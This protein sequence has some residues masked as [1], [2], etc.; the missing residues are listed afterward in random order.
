MKRILMLTL[1]VSIVCFLTSPVLADDHGDSW[2]SATPIIVGG[3]Y[4][5]ILESQTDVDFFSCSLTVG[6][7][8]TVETRVEGHCDTVMDLYDTDGVTFLAQD[9]DGGIG[10]GSKMVGEVDVSGIYYIA[11]FPYPYRD[12]TGRY[13]ISVEEERPEPEVVGGGSGGGCF[14]I[15]SRQ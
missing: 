3:V 13:T 12:S 5:G 2:T 6:V 14:I 4:S 1:F 7:T 9:D 15:G 10:Y 11:I 8:Y